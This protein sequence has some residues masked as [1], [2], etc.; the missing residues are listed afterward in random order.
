VASFY[1]YDPQFRGG[2]DVAVGDVDGDG[3][4]DIVTGAGPG[5]AP[6]V[7]VFDRD[8]VPKDFGSFFAYDEHFRGGVH[9][10]VVDYDGDGIAE[11][12]TAPGPGGGPHVRVFDFVQGLPVIASEFMA[13]DATWTG[14]VYATGLYTDPES[15]IQSI[16]TGV[17]A[18]GGAHV[19]V[20]DRDGLPTG[21]SVYAFDAYTGGVS[22]AATDVDN[23]GIDEIVAGELAAPGRVRTF[24]LDGQPRTNDFEWTAYEGGQG[25]QLSVYDAAERV[26]CDLGRAILGGMTSSPSKVGELGI[27]FPA[28]GGLYD[29]YPGFPGGARVSGGCRCSDDPPGTTTSTT[30]PTP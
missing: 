28:K 24:H 13:Y 20:F 22:V 12:V 6:H 8:G 26:C 16:L 3:D 19:R 27:G 17:G 1:A 11:I 15:D 7:R 4:P 14:G 23:D 2:V 9:V 21:V 5:G 25:V 10:G 18:G 30:F 29:P